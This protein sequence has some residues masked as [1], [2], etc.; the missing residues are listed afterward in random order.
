VQIDIERMENSRHFMT[1]ILCG[2]WIDGSSGCRRLWRECIRQPMN[3]QRI[4]LAG[5]PEV[6]LQ[7]VRNAMHP[8][9]AI[10]WVARCDASQ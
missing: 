2:G 1:T 9:R 8:L 5:R 7:R 3:A 10:H 6:M 4:T